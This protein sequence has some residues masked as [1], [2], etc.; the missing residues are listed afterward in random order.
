MTPKSEPLAAVDHDG[1]VSEGRFHNYRTNAIPIAVYLI[2][3][4]F[5]IGAV[6]YLV[7]YLLPALRLEIVNPP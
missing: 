4:L 3:I 7:T 5:W 2:W 6:Y 1:P